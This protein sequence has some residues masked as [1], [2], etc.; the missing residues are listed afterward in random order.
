MESNY[1][2]FDYLKGI[3]RI[4]EILNAPAGN[5]EESDSIPARSKL[6][7]TNGYYVNCAA[8]F[9]DM[10]GS[11]NL[12]QKHT[13][14][15]LAKIY[16]SYI[17]EIVAVMNGNTLCKEINIIGDCVSG[18][19]DTP[20]KSNIDQVFGSA[21]TISSMID[22]LNCKLKKKGY[23]EVEIGIGIDYGRALMI[24]AGY[25]GSGIND[26]VWMGEVV[27]QASKLCGKA[28]KEWRPEIIVSSVFYSNLNDHNKGLLTYN[29]NGEFYQGNVINTDINEWVQENCNK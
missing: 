9:V 13:R 17:S 24:K 11:S 22:V 21:Y 1:S 16:R 26:V 8:M 18:I 27:N 6:T 25:S 29:S 3:D 2:Y 19:F 5:F 10:R 4:D 28:N 23:S 14:P 20:Y 12:P 15:V 7:Y